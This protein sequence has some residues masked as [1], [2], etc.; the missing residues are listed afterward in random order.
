MGGVKYPEFAFINEQ[1]IRSCLSNVCFFELRLEQ[2]A[3][4][5]IFYTDFIKANRK[6]PDI[7]W[8]KASILPFFKKVGSERVL[9]GLPCLSCCAR[10]AKGRLVP[11]SP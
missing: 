7:K 11:Q 6:I 1:L 4:C 3:L 5:D 9:F 8:E 2:V 10:G